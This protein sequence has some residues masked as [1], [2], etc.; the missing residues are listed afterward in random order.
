MIRKAAFLLIAASIVSRIAGA[1]AVE[2]P[3]ELYDGISKFRAGLV[4]A[5]RAKL[6]IPFESEERLNWH[7]VP[8]ERVGLSYADMTPEQSENATNVLK[9]L[10]SAAG[11]E[12][13]STIR[14]LEDVLR[15][16]GGDPK[17]RDRNKYHFYL[18]GEPSK[19]Q[20]WG[21]RYE[22]HHLSLNW[23]VHENKLISST[24]QFLGSNPGEVREGAKAGLS[25]LRR[26][27]ELGRALVV[28]LTDEQRA[29]AVLS[30]T[31]PPDILTGADR[32]AAIQED[33]GIAFRELT[34]LQQGMLISIIQEHA[35]V[36]RIDVS[37]A[38]LEDI[39]KLGLDD[40]KFA[41]MGGL[42]KAQGHYYRVQ[43]P[44]FLIEYDNTQNDAN[45]I[46]A[47]WRDF[48]GDFGVDALK[49]HYQAN[50]APGTAAHAH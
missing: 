50:A 42:D 14:D 6:E 22:G 30:A 36:Q 40:I 9:N 17:V 46:H 24:A 39:R 1:Q 38:R 48:K 41:W 2:V 31:A 37:F 5:Q 20:P 23:T 10:V 7:F 49:G 34:A 35:S 47:V 32:E 29:K 4:E 43:G 19:D 26:E 44:T 11:F 12:K 18:F 27:E 13:V 8:K 28:S 45:H 25:P 3:Q 16:Q 15:E 21:F 33:L